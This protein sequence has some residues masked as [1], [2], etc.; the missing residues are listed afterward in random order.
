MNLSQLNQA[1]NHKIVEGS[2]YQWNCYPNARYLDYES[3]FAHASIL[4]S[5]VDQTIY[6][7]E[8]HDKG[9]KFQYRWLNPSY[10]KAYYEEAK[11]KNVDPD[12]AWDTVKWTDLE[13][14]SDFLEKAQAMFEG[15]SFDERIQIPIDFDDDLLL[16]LFKK[17]HER[18]ITFNQLVTEALQE[19]I[20]EFHRDPEGVKARMEKYKDR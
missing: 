9:Y 14:E 13:V 10:S 3:D 16:E 12:Q 6:C 2:D 1:F 5:S 20:D 8:V 19:L 11:E 18:D 7:A 4:F 17:A 15:K